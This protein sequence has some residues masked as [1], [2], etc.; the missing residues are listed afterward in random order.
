MLHVV[1]GA[2]MS[3]DFS[4]VDNDV[5]RIYGVVREVGSLIACR[6]AHAHEV[7]GDMRPIRHRY[8]PT[9]HGRYIVVYVMSV[10]TSGL[11]LLLVVFLG[12]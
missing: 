3:F 8:V 1:L 10:D 5:L 12:W 4:L 11:H 9:A 7:V 2:G 6:V